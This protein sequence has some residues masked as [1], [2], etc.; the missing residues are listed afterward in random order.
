MWQ[1]DGVDG[2]AKV[3]TPVDTEQATREDTAA[4]TVGDTATEMVNE[5][6]QLGFV[7][8]SIINVVFVG[9]RIRLRLLRRRI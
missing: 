5:L 2:A 6:L 3:D 8:F 4:A 7:V 1:L 9:D